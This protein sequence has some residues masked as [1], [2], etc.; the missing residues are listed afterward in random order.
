MAYTKPLVTTTVTVHG[1][2]TAIVFQDD[3]ANGVTTRDGSN[4]RAQILKG[5]TIEAF[6][7]DGNKEIIP[8]HAV[9]MAVIEVAPS[10]AQTKPEDDFC[11]TE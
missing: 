6:D 11:A 5:E 4:A 10:E 2:D 3:I 9:I 8:Y 7:S 1:L